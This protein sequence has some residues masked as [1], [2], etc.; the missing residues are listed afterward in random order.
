MSKKVDILVIGGGPAGMVCAVTAH[1]Y[2]PD[3]K[4]STRELFLAEFPICSPAWIIRNRIYLVLR[5]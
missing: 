3:K 1:R 5:L 4:I 2:Y